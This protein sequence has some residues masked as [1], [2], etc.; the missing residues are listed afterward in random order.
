MIKDIALIGLGYIGKIHLRLLKENANWN[1]V[2][3]YDI[4]KKLARD[5]A[6]QYDVKAYN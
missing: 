1:V 4:D 2:G 5:L 6:L 3:V